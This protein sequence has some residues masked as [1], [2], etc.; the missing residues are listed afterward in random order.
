MPSPETSTAGPSANGPG[1]GTI[2]DLARRYWDGVLA[3]SPTSATLL[4]IHD[5]DDRLEDLSV[6]ADDRRH[7]ELTA[8][9]HGLEEATPTGDAERV[10]A[11]LLG[12]QLRTELDAIDMRLAEMARAAMVGAHAEL[13]MA[14]PQLTYPTA[15][16]AE[17]ALVR[18]QQV[19]R[20]LGQALDR[21]RDGLA[22]GR[23]PGNVCPRR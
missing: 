23:T 15:R 6:E 21:F 1:P 17:A 22:A 20:L 5:H 12:H 11:A 13:L 7:A 9:V 2:P 4:G 8:L 10:T 18:Y 16:D 3:A 14:V 19:P